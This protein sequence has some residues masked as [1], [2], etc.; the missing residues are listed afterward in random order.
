MSL[1]AIYFLAGSGAF[2]IMLL[3]KLACEGNSCLQNSE[4]AQGQMKP[5]ESIIWLM[6]KI[7]KVVSWPTV[8]ISTPSYWLIP[9]ISYKS[10]VVA[11]PLSM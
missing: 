7:Q 2:S 3:L 4:N 6:I 11:L 9:F 8:G 1:P 5:C 10:N